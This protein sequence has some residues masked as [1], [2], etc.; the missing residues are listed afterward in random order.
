MSIWSMMLQRCN[1]QRNRDY[2][3]YG[4]RGITVC[5][6]WRDVQAFVDDMGTPPKGMTLE[7]IDNDGPYEPGNCKWAT[8][9]EQGAN[10]RNTVHYV[11]DGE[12]THAEGAA[13]LLGTTS[14]TLRTW[15]KAGLTDAEITV[16][17]RSKKRTRLPT[18]M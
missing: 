12:Q 18:S 6:R 8:R 14:G 11:I 5:D 3:Q 13:R 16:R 4:G 7:R 9:A 17:A 2:P 10:K 15:R 1:N